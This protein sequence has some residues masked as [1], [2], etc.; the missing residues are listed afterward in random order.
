MRMSLKLA[1]LLL[2]LC[3][4]RPAVKNIEA[5]EILLHI[6]ASEDVRAAARKLRV[7]TAVQPASGQA[8]ADRPAVTLTADDWPFDIPVIPRDPARPA[9]LIQIVAEALDAKGAIVVQQRALTTFVSE[10]QRVLSLTLAR[11]GD[12]ELGEICE[13]DAQC[14]GSQCQNCVSGACSDTKLTPG[15]DL[16]RVGSSSDGLGE[17]TSE[18]K[19]GKGATG[20]HGDAEMKAGSG[21]SRD[22]STAGMG[23]RSGAG[24]SSAQAG[25]AGEAGSGEEP[26]LPSNAAASCNLSTQCGCENGSACNVVRIEGNKAT[27]GCTKLEAEPVAEGGSCTSFGVC[28]AGYGCVGPAPQICRRHCSSD[29]DCGAN[30]RCRDVTRKVDKMVVP[31]DGVRA[32]FE[33]CASGGDCTTG[34]CMDGVCAATDECM[35]APAKPSSDGKACMDGN[36]RVE[37]TVS[38]SPECLACTVDNCCDAWVKCQKDPTCLCALECTSKSGDSQA[39]VT[40][41]GGGNV[42][43]TYLEFGTCGLGSCSDACLDDCSATRAGFASGTCEPVKQCGC[44][45]SENCAVEDSAASITVCKAEG[46]KPPGEPCSATIECGKGYGCLDGICKRYCAQDTSAE[47]GSFAVCKPM[48]YSNNLIQGAFFCSRAC[49]PAD[50]EDPVCRDGTSCQPSGSLPDSKAVDDRPSDCYR[51]RPNVGTEA[52]CFNDDGVADSAMCAR[53]YYCSSTS[54]RC[55]PYCH[56]DRSDECTGDTTCQSFARKWTVLG[57]EIGAC[58]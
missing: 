49:D 53:G 43:S 48:Y 47:C 54:M 52:S 26:C 28:R 5:T 51:L 11:C 18:P 50:A 38:G 20:N 35:A 29:S 22:S 10:A 45:A 13:S 27:I 55:T 39:C 24:G 46:T 33:A 44:A 21:G 31:V 1:L 6:D 7:H 42:P 30:R 2:G 12:R 9:K 15:A 4:C 23:G 14:H 8:W 34:C 17:E 41:C 40:A 25:R 58:R 57:R 16:P 3:A 19:A 37:L 32:C 56:M 36:T